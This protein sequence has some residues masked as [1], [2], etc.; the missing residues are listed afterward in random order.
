M[1]LSH[2]ALALLLV[3]FI[4]CG[5]NE[6]ITPPEDTQMN[7]LTNGQW[8]RVQ[9]ELNGTDVWAIYPACAKDD[10]LV[11][12]RDGSAYIDQGT[13]ICDTSSP[14]RTYWTW[15]FSEDQSQLLDHVNDSTTYIRHIRVLS[16]DSLVYVSYNGQD[17]LV[18]GFVKQ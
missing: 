18:S 9:H 1:K 14:Q 13:M 8:K 11:Y 2:F 15:E 4:S 6:E 10:P 7:W 3:V 12:I 16:E 17:S 5:D